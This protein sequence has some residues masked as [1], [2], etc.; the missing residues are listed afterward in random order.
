MVFVPFTIPGEE[1]EV[2][3]AREKKNYAEAE[4]LS[5]AKSSPDRCQPVCEYFGHC[6]GCAYQ[7]MQYKLQLELKSNQVEQLLRR[8]GGVQNVPMR[9]I[10]A[11]PDPY[12]YRSRIRVHVQHGV[13]GFYAYSTHDLIDVA[14]CPIASPRINLMLKEF[15]Q[16]PLRDGDYVLSESGHGR[17]FEQANPKVAELMVA[18]VGELLPDNGDYLIDAYCGAGLFAKAFA[19][20][21]KRVV[22][23]EENEQAV[24]AARSAA[25]PNENYFCGDVAVH[26]A[27]LLLKTR[28]STLLL[29]PPAVGLAQGV[30]AAILS[31]PPSDLIYVSCNPGTLAR[32]LKKMVHLYELQ[33]VTPLDMFAQTAEIEVVA[34]LSLSALHSRTGAAETQ[35][36]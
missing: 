4:L 7:H 23:I 15:R 22:G 11:A 20:K 5:V 6:G 1:V 26:L 19:R 10:I 12:G 17:F 28:N 2:R 32:D 13:T 16:R 18:L 31:N 14:R 25:G 29:D 30:I 35:T 9:P 3:I 24:E 21:F 34:H 8:I 36:I 27:E 33:S